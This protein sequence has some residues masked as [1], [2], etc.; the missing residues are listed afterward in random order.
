MSERRSRVLVTGATGLAGSHTVRA[1]L[2]AGHRVRALVRNPDKARRVFKGQEGPL[3]NVPGDINDITSV[4]NAL[5][6]CDAV[7]H[8]AA[9]VSINAPSPETLIETNVSGVHNVV[10]TAVEQGLER[11][12]HVSSLA[13]LFRG[14]GT[15]ISE[16]SEPQESKHAYGHSKTLAER[17]VRQLQAEGHPVKITYPSAIIGPD[18]PGLTESMVGIQTWIRDFVPLTTA[19][20]QF[21]D[22]RDL[23]IAHVRMV[24]AEPGPGRYLVAGTFLPW[25]EIA[26]VI[27]ATTGRRPRTIRFPAPLLRGLGRLLDLIRYVI[28]VELPLSAEAAKYVTKWDPVPNS[29]ALEAMGVRFRDVSESIGDAARW[30][31][32]AGYLDRKR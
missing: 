25:L 8:C 16:S 1:L 7:I 20:M 31:R 28:P 17:Y 15:T 9:I 29:K 22:A 13:T 24:E 18:D 6:G 10:G 3:E 5:S 19:G 11:I 23:A 21:I 26:N 2:D 27:E 30:L 14:D 32:E 4:R 12:I